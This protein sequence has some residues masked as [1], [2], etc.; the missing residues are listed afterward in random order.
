MN[1]CYLN[2]P[3]IYLPQVAKNL[4]SL[5]PEHLSNS[6]FKRTSKFLTHPIFNTH[7]SETQLVRYMKILENKDVS[8]VHSMIP[9][10]SRWWS[11]TSKGLRLGR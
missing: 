11:G 3:E 7:H 8:L 6:Q 2:L 4:G 1:I 9:L 10:V 5:P